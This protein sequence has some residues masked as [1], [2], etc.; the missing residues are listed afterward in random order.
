[1]RV[2]DGKGVTCA[3]GLID[4]HVHVTAV[5][6]LERLGRAGVTTVLDMGGWGPARDPL[7]RPD[8]GRTAVFT[9]GL[10]AV[11]PGGNHARMPGLPPEAIITDPAQAGTFVQ[12]RLTE[13]ARYIKV[14][15]EH[16]GAG[17]PTPA[18]VAAITDCAHRAGVLVVAHTV[19]E[20]AATLAVDAGV[21]I[22]THTPLDV[23]WSPE[24]IAR[25]RDR[26]IP[27]IPTLVMM[28][29]IAAVRPGAHLAAA[30]ET[31]RRLRDAGVR[32]LAGTDA[33]STPG[34]PA[35]VAFGTSLHRELHL[36]TTAGFTPAEAL[37]A[38]THDTAEVFGLPGCGRLTPGTCADLILLDGDLSTR[39]APLTHPRA[40]LIGGRKASAVASRRDRPTR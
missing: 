6:D 15:V 4:A 9:S 7:L 14:V 28:E 16:P 3:P 36:L 22:L 39:L 30:V 17:G 31:V 29:A 26:D 21:D 40:Q 8:I 11:G 18:A 12:A 33:N 1:V 25:L 20:A 34:A 10:L 38:A 23:P 37:R 2:L 19:P 5:D 27:V 35:A 32:V 24:F 13:G